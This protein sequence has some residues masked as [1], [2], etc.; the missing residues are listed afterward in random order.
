MYFSLKSLLS[1]SQPICIQIQ[2]SAMSHNLF[3]H[4]DIFD[5][6]ASSPLDLFTNMR[7]Y[8]SFNISLF[9]KLNNKSQLLS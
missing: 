5:N 9:S 4:E 3:F 8:E 1:H 7:Q 2:I 6:I